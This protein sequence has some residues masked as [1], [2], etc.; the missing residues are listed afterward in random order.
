MS[1]TGLK[2]QPTGKLLDILTDLEAS[3]GEALEPLLDHL[4]GGTSAE[5]LAETLTEAGAPIGATTIKA[6]RRKLRAAA[7]TEGSVKL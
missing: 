7:Q 5:W 6:Y 4:Q 1:V 2:V 3:F